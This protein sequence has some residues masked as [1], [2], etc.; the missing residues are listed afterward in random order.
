[1]SLDTNATRY[2]VSLFTP[3]TNKDFCCICNEKTQEP[4]TVETM[5]R[6]HGI[7]TEYHQYC[8]HCVRR[9]FEI[10]EGIW[11]LILAN[12]PHRLHTQMELR[13]AIVPE[14]QAKIKRA[15]HH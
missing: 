9:H 8:L 10:N 12:D 14:K 7:H 5:Q 13:K 4:V 2:Y 6:N 11:E 1:M 3:R 15:F